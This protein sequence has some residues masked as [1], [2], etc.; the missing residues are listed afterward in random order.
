MESTGTTSEKRILLI[1]LSALGDIVHALPALAAIRH[2]FPKA[3]VG[4]LVEDRGAGL[5]E[6]HPLL[7]AV[8]IIPR[9]AWR[10][11]PFGTLTGPMRALVSELRD[12]SYD[13]A[14]DF[15]GLTKSAFWAKLCGA[16]ERIGFSGEEA[17][18]VS[19]VFYNRAVFPRAN[20]IHVIERNL[21]LLRPLGIE[22]PQVEFPIHL[23]DETR[24]FGAS[25]WGELGDRYPRIVMNP[26][27]GW[28]TKQWPAAS[29]GRLAAELVRE[30]G[31]RVALAWG[32]GE[33]TLVKTALEAAGEHNGRSGKRSS[34][35]GAEPVIY[36]LP[37]TSFM[38]LGAAA[39]RAHLFI[40][41]DTGPTHLAAALGIPTLGLYGASDSKRNGPWGARTRVIQ[42]TDL[43]CVPCWKTYCDWDEPLACLTHI[44]IPQ[45][46][47]ACLKLLAG[48]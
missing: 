27:A 35:I 48:I 46:R 18:E 11:N 37:P 40:G 31:A 16:P 29:Y 41:G 4:W 45:V 30:V 17:R 25:I 9:K 13:T 43:S 44:Q 3:F 6:G 7:D 10:E 1:R 14:I 2:V 20:Q 39:A 34:T 47:E 36:A 38:E 26:G 15:Q 42:L 33:E 21:S 28:V 5:I 8:H 24:A 23:Q 19:R 22:N 12:Q 32:P